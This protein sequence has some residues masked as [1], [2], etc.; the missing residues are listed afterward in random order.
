MNPIDTAVLAAALVWN[1]LL[2]GL[3]FAFACAIVPGLRR[4]DD[5]TYVTAFRAINQAIVNAVFLLVFL[6]AP[7]LAAVTVVLRPADV[8][9]PWLI[10][11]LVCAIATFAITVG[12]NVPLNRRLDDAAV[13]TAAELAAARGGFERRW[14]AAHL[15]RTLTGIGAVAFLAIAVLV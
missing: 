9:L 13:Q 11:G 6:G 10:A 3:F 7:L 8:A 1:G 2:A 5:H 4:V 14:N 12:V 15:V